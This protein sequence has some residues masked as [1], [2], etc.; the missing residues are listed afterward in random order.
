ME[1]NAEKEARR[2]AMYA[3]R[4]KFWSGIGKVD[5][6]AGPYDQPCFHGSA[7]MA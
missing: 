5:A 2:E 7:R 4:Q 1:E 3:A 6:D